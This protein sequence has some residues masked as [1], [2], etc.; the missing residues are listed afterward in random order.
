[1]HIST[2][3]VRCSVNREQILPQ[4]WGQKAREGLGETNAVLRARRLRWSP[5]CVSCQG[6]RVSPCFPGLHPPRE[7][8]M[9]ALQVVL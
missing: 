1:M 6:T 5:G 8:R 9:L 3:P 7:L 2:A 4:D